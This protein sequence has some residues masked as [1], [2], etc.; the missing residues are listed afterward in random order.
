[1]KIKVWQAYASNN[2][3]SYTIIGR[4]PDAQLAQQVAC[5]LNQLLEK[6]NEW[7]FFDKWKT[8]KSPLEEFAHQH[9]LHFDPSNDE[10]DWPMAFSDDVLPEP[11][12]AIALRDKVLIHHQY[13]ISLPAMLGQYFYARGGRVREEIT[14]AEKP[15]LAKFE[16]VAPFEAVRSLRRDVDMKGLAEELM[17]ED[18]PLK[19]GLVSQTIVELVKTGFQGQTIKFEARFTDLIKSFS[20]ISEIVNKYEV[21]LYLR[22]IA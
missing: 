8:E 1:M 4:F 19:T 12:R 6:Y 7:V 16:I 9:N 13:T 21:Q 11:P 2:S 20:K 22:L 3:G 5:D 17:A 18:G 10:D 15:L 14:M